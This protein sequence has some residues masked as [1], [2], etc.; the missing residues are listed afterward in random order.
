MASKIAV[1]LVSV[2][3]FWACV[4]LTWSGWSGNTSENVEEGSNANISLL[5]VVSLN[6]AHAQPSSWTGPT[7]RGRKYRVRVDSAPQ[8]AA[9][10][11]QD[12]KHG[13]VGYTP[14]SGRLGKGT[15]SVILKK[16]GYKTE[17]RTVVVKR[18]KRL[19]ES[20]IPM[21]RQARPSRVEVR[22]ATDPKASGAELWVDGVSKG[23]VPKTV[24]VSLGRHLIEVKK[25][26]FKSFTQWI[27]V[28]E[29]ETVSLNPVLKSN[30]SGRLIVE[31]DV[32]GAEVF[33]DGKLHGDKTPT[34]V[35]GLSSGLHTVE[36]RKE[37]ASPWQKSVQ[38]KDGET[39]KIIAILAGSG[40]R[41]ISDKV[42][43]SVF[44]DGIERGVTP[45]ELP[46][47]SEGEHLFEVRF[48]GLPPK[49]T[50]VDVEA[51]KPT[52]VELNF[53]VPDGPTGTLT[54]VSP[55]PEAKVFIDGQEAGLVPQ[56]RILSEGVHYVVVQKEGFAK[57]QREVEVAAGQN[58]TLQ[59][60]LS[61]AG[62]A[63]ILSK[64]EGAEIFVD[65]LS[66]GFAPLPN[67]D[68]PAGEHII[69]LRA[70]G[71]YDYEE[72]VVIIP[73]DTKIINAR[74]E[75]LE[76]EP[77]ANDRLLEQRGLTS[78]GA[79]TM[80]RGRS[81]IDLGVGYP[82]FL[83]ARFI[84]GAPKIAD[85]FGFDVGVSLKTMLT[86]TEL[87]IIARLNIVDSD[88][89]SF[90]TFAQ[91]GGGATFFDNS[92]RNTFFADVGAAVSLTGLGAVTLTGRAYLNFYSDR[93]C[94]GAEVAAQRFTDRD[95]DPVSAC[96]N[97]LNGTISAEDRAKIDSLTGGPNELFKRD[98]GVRL[99]TSFLIEL[100][101]QQRMNVWV[102]L[103]GPPFQSERAAFTNFFSGVMLSNDPLLYPRVGVTY[104][105]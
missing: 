2:F 92:N 58:E 61:A 37:P 95:A 63:K 86:R 6:Q 36:V 104:K 14:W 23:A 21:E 35:T 32:P 39:L 17:T 82:H 81:T 70:P 11:L 28:S 100:A 13:I 73:G 7:P 74:L 40:V 1:R 22:A 45:A 72:N 97:Y 98:I 56:T 27:D 53:D 57:Y 96:R 25:D 55:V 102:L 85:R 52:V 10:Y 34:V 44:V 24:N 60:E 67:L 101:I 5:G 77:T 51:G 20:F 50:K 54:V 105:F 68:V 90:G 43:A 8:Q 16:D 30:G 103:E 62:L 79:R 80:G 26:G 66:V 41:V 84:V 46:N 38:V 15:W 9:V 33:I 12:E 87:G 88:P 29:G 59:V 69:S 31:A 89:F 48:K 71:F 49:R 76:G 99:I 42:G 18:T 94:P 64:P 19:Q 4:S 83:D 75:S 65:G 78:Y 93:L 47:L 3:A 91:V